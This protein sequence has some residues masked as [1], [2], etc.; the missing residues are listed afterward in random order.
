[1]LRALYSLAV[2]GL[3]SPLALLL[4]SAG[5]APQ[6]SRVF[7]YPTHRKTL[8]NGLQVVVVPF[9]SPGLVAHWVVVRVGSR[10]E[11]EPGHSGFAHFFE[12]MMFRGTPKYPEDRYN[13]IIKQMGADSNAFTSDD[14]TAYHILAGSAAL[15]QIMEIE[16]DRFMNLRYEKEAFQKEARA[17]LGEYNK[18]FSFPENSIDEKLYDAAFQ[19]HPYKHTTMGFLRDI[20]DMPNQYDYSLMFYDRYY[21]PEHCILL[22]VGDVKPEE[23]FALAERSYGPWKRGSYTIQ[24]PQ[25]PPQVKEKQVRID[26]KNPTLP[27]LTLGYHG[28]A[29]SVQEKDMPALDLIS[30]IAFSETS[31]LYRKLVIEEQLVD[32]LYG[33]AADRRDP[34]LFVISARVKDSESIPKVQAALDA[35]LED[36]KAQP[37]DSRRLEDTKSHL[38]YSFQMRLDTADSVASTLTHI[39]E[40]TGDPEAYNELYRTYDSL[41]AADLQE[42]ARKYFRKENRTVVLLSSASASGNGPKP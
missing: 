29:F 10:N 19:I 6:G 28:P 36:L 2:A 17:V 27:Y 8:P 15:P 24:I 14:L 22:V 5:A 26:W 13:A 23:V 11:I 18:N 20:E 12:H 42:V 40:L 41:S 35:T 4:T 16:S 3:M 37:A 21:R 39:L 7:P 9:D 38:K 1:M 30:Q 31:P 34:N 25:E 33:G 32:S